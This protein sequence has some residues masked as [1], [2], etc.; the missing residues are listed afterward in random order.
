MSVQVT[1]QGKAMLG[2]KLLE[3]VHGIIYQ[4]KSCWFAATKVGTE[5][6]AGDHIRC[7]FVHL[8]QLLRDLL[9]G[10]GGSAGVQ[11]IYDLSTQFVST[12]VTTINFTNK[13]TI[14]FLAKSRLVM[15]LRVR[16]VAVTSAYFIAKRK[17]MLTK[18]PCKAAVSQCVC[19]WQKSAPKHLQT[20][21]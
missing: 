11:D 9:L 10:D 3:E 19:D 17:Y 16:I 13:L 7:D 20:Q 12:L 15:N 6:K 21:N 5:T 4:S 8:G 14:C 1:N 2:F 18:K